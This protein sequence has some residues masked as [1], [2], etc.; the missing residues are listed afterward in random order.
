[1]SLNDVVTARE[2]VQEPRVDLALSLARKA[3]RHALAH[4]LRAAVRWKGPG[5]RVTQ[6]DIAIQ[7]RLIEEIRTW[8]PHDGI[9]A[10]EGALTIGDGEFTW[11]LDPLDG[12][13]NYVLG[14]PC[15]STSIGILRDGNPW[16]GIVHD[17]N[18]GL[19]CWA[20]RGQGAFA[21]DR[22]LRLVGRPLGPASNLALRAPIEPRLAS[23]ALDWL[24]RYKLRSFGS[25]ALQLVYTAVGAI[26]AM[27]DDR[28]RLWDLTGGAAI[29]L[30]AGGRLTDFEGQNLFPV[31]LGRYSGQPL[32]FVAGNETAHR[33]VLARLTSALCAR[34]SP[35]PP[36][37]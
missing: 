14:I 12:T 4:R 37:A 5:D 25:V 3:G 2:R 28:A 31:D 30:E 13:N 17:P 34:P 16:A 27:I 22:P 8:F 26:D 33:V 11:V 29:L 19:T 7:S 1:V 9:V 35:L 6:V 18:T 24:T 15:F 32:P 10:E 21:D 20:I 36:S 23:I